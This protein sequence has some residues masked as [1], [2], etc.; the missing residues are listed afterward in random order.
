MKMPDFV[1]GDFVRIVSSLEELGNRR[2]S[3]DWYSPARVPFLGKCAR[4]TDVFGV[5]DRQLYYLCIDKG[6][7]NWEACHLRKVANKG[8]G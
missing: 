5:G 8:G 2:H 6:Y 7:F 4:I 1:R 3:Y